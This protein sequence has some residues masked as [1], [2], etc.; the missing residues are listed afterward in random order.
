MTTENIKAFLQCYSLQD[1]SVLTV[2]G[3]G[4]QV[5]N[6][7]LLGA[8]NVT[9][10]DVNPLAFYQVCL[11]IAA[12]QVLTYEEFLDFF[13]PEFLHLFDESL[14]NKISSCLDY[15]AC[16]FFKYIYSRYNTSQI[17]DKVYYDFIPS[18]DHMKKMNLY[19]EE[20][21][22]SG[23]RDILINKKPSFIESDVTLLPNKLG[24]RKF[25]LIML[26]NISESI[27]DIWKKDAIITYMKT[28]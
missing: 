5:L 23:L 19:L 21:N 26:S 4:D 10:F 28:K 24:D 1:S 17:L 25:D 22:Y 7:Y 12:V 11:K 20:S 15:D 27:E 2:C 18:L 8:K 6:A 16:E 3:S 9:C 14:F 13:F